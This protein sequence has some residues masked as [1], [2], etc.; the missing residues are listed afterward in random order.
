VSLDSQAFLE[1]LCD[2]L[3]ASMARGRPI[4]IE[5]E[6]DDRP[7]SPDQAISLGLIINELVTN[8]IKHAFPEGR[9]GRIRVGFEALED[10]LR[11]CVEDDGVG[12]SGRI[13][14]NGGMGQDVVRG[15]SRELGG[16][17][18]VKTT[19]R[20]SSFRLS[21]PYFSTKAARPSAALIH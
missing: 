1:D 11:L 19:N 18:E 21:I 5:C 13:R 14:S 4:A 12:F 3:T 10:Q 20:G 17:L 6:A 16:D 15:L 8:A 9:A 2:E 7:L